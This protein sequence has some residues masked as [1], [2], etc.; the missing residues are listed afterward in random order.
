MILEFTIIA[1]RG[2]FFCAV[3]GL[4]YP[5][6]LLTMDMDASSSWFSDLCNKL[7]RNDPETTQIMDPT[8]GLRLLSLEEESSNLLGEAFL[9]NNIVTD[10]RLC[11]H[12]LEGHG[13]NSHHAILDAIRACKNLKYVA[14]S[15]PLRSSHLNHSFLGSLALNKA[16]EFVGLY[17]MALGANSL[18]LLLLG[19][20]RTMSTF[21][22]GFCRLVVTNGIEL[23]NAVTAFRDHKYLL[24]LR[25]DI[26]YGMFEALEEAIVSHPILREL[27]IDGALYEGIPFF[28]G[29][30]AV[31][32]P[33]LNMPSVFSVL[34][35]IVES[36]GSALQHL[37]LEN[38]LFNRVGTSFAVLVQSIL[39]NQT[40]TKLTFGGWCT[41]D[42]SPVQPLV[43]IYQSSSSNIQSLR[44]R[45][46]VT[47]TRL[48]PLIFEHPIPGLKEL[49]VSGYIIVEPSTIRL[50][51][52]GA[53]MSLERCKITQLMEDGCHT[54]IQVLP[55]VRKLKELIL[56]L[57]GATH[58]L[59][60]DLLNAIEKNSSLVKVMVYTT[61]DSNT[62]PHDDGEEVYF[63]DNQ[64]TKVGLYT[65]RN[66]LLPQMLLGEPYSEFTLSLL[67]RLFHIAKPSWM[68]SCYVFGCLLQ[69]KDVIGPSSEHKSW[70]GCGTGT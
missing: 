10:V 64:L 43:S 29:I 8:T 6:R 22:L 48:L 50:L 56:G 46:S 5:Q 66:E 40:L 44:F 11:Y 69:L 35:S 9:G 33:H 24:S 38:F 28:E 25:L 13:A 39:V 53:M 55:H 63:S 27:I 47:Y 68:G 52:S 60:E 19:S 31:T 21:H 7:Q 36:P 54:L 58:H 67:P 14:F 34:C 1:Y 4:L 17:E 20:G 32:Y 12:K 45:Q 49:E 30:R 41:F 23:Q 61:V 16:L 42:I 62:Y 2:L 3:R 57:S 26:I 70:K 37:Q 18:S 59:K 15:G 51:T 65:R